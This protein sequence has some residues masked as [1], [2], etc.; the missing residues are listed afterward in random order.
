MSASWT[1]GVRRA[2]AVD[3]WRHRESRPTRRN[4][5]YLSKPAVLACA[6]ARVCVRPLSPYYI[7]ISKPLGRVERRNAPVSQLAVSRFHLLPRDSRRRRSSTIASLSRRPIACLSLSFHFD[8]CL[9]YMHAQGIVCAG[10]GTRAPN[11]PSFLTLPFSLFPLFLTFSLS[12]SLSHSLVG[13]LFDALPPRS[14]LLRNVTLT[15]G[16]GA[17]IGHMTRERKKSKR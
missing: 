9:C 6:S 11:H 16:E 15:S 1:P 3:G 5:K 8:A 14:T 4:R 2:T 10:V 17:C 13:F 12:F 7:R